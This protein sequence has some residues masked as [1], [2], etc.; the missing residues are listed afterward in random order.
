LKLPQDLQ[1]LKLIHWL[2]R[3][4]LPGTENPGFFSYQSINPLS[5]PS[6][7]HR[8]MPKSKETILVDTNKQAW[9]RVHWLL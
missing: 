1:E 9:T 5:V 7:T 6:G 8:V 3:M 4:E 2:L